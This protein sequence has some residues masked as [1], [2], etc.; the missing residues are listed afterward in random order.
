MC[1][2]RIC[3]LAVLL[4]STI[5]AFIIFSVPG[6]LGRLCVHVCMCLLAVL[7]AN[8]VRTLMTFSALM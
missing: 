4:G 2:Q 7:P 1:A 3:L 8:T 6:V 5:H